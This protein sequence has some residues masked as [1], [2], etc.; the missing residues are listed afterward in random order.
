MILSLEF[1]IE[2]AYA[3]SYL[4]PAK[5]NDTSSTSPDAKKYIQ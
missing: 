2:T 3:V 1:Y 4:S 5:E